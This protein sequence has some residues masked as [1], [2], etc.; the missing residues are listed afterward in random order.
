MPSPNNLNLLGAQIDPPDNPGTWIGKL[1]RAKICAILTCLLKPRLVIPI[2]NGNG[3]PVPQDAVITMGRNGWTAVFPA[4]AAAG[5]S[6]TASSNVPFSGTVDPPGGLPVGNYVAGP[7]PSLYVNLTAKTLWVCT[8]SG[9][10]ATSVW[11]QVS[12]GGLV[13]GNGP[14]SATTLT[15]GQYSSNQVYVDISAPT[16]PVFWLC[17]TAG[18]ASTSVWVRRPFYTYATGDPT[19]GNPGELGNVIEKWH[20]PGDLQWS[21]NHNALFVCTVGGNSSLLPDP[22]RWQRVSQTVLSGNGSPV[23]AATITTHDNPPQSILEILP[24]DLYF[25]VTNKNLW[26]C[27]VGSSP[28]NAGWVQIGIS[29]TIYT[30]SICKVNSDGSTTTESLQVYGPPGQTI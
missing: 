5:A 13:A 10:N 21:Q 23:G 28:P 11:A 9:T 18:N 12:G 30:V 2:D 6:G 26:Y 27:T 14:P 24:G 19:P 4:L 3:I 29:G 22:V 16:A 7:T 17:Q 20:L 25:D 1:W 8:T 15:A